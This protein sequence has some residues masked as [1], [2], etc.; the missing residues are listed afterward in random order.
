M[1]LARF[2]AW[3]D[4]ALGGGARPGS[5]SG[6]VSRGG[7]LPA[8]RNDVPLRSDSQPLAM[9]ALLSVDGGGQFLLCGAERLT[10]GH[11][12][13]G[14][15]DLG[16]LADLG[17]LHATLVRADSLQD[18][19][20]WRIE[21]CGAERVCVA[22]VPLAGGR[23]LAPHERVRLGENLEF[24]V[25]APDAASASVV[26]ELLHGVECAGA[27]HVVLLARGP[28]GRVRIGAALG[29]HV[30]V[31]GLAFDLALEWHAGELHVRSE[32]PLAGA[33]TGEHGV[34]PFPPRTRLAL[35]C[36]PAR[37]SHPPFGLS[38]EPVERLAGG[39]G[40]P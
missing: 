24:E 31:P 40:R 11:V 3:L 37:G 4:R 1:D 20:G 8:M 22:G 17:A 35:S 16:F 2:F 21:P 38:F 9:A 23:R 19:P 30:R 32:E 33:I 26:L 12:R 39:G 13:A 15:A 7:L 6:F 36:G 18:G 14:R 5:D 28:G 10:L 25:R 34:L 27:R 29:H